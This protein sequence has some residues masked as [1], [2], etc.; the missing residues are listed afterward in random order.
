MTT[1]TISIQVPAARTAPRLASRFG[2]LAA[3]AI[4]LFNHP[5][6]Q[7]PVIRHVKP[8]GF[9]PWPTATKLRTRALRR[10]CTQRPTGTRCFT[11]TK[12][13]ALVATK[14]PHLAG[15]FVGESFADQPRL[16]SSLALV[17]VSSAG[18]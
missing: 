11:A 6:S 12:P 3:A 9:V 1:T 5:A 13:S 4:A 10:S 7:R 17:A 14:S 18:R 15:F 8:H 2:D 16:A